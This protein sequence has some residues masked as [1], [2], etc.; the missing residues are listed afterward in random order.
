[1]LSCAALV[2]LAPDAAEGVLTEGA[3]QKKVIE[4]QESNK[5]TLDELTTKVGAG[6]IYQAE[7]RRR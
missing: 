2:L 4:K 7:E 5:K 1:M 6:G 3:F